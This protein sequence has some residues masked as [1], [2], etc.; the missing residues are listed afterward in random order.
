MRRPLVGA[1]TTLL[2]GGAA[3]TGIGAAPA[4][5]ASQTADAPRASAPQAG[6]AV[7][8]EA[9]VKAKPKAVDFAG[10]VAL[11]NCSGS[12]IRL[13]NSADND[14][15]LVLTNG[16]CLETGMPG[17]GDVI[18][19]QASSRTFSLLNSTA[20]KAGTLRASKVAYATMTDTDVTLYQLTTTYAQIKKSYGINALNLS[21][22]H[23]ATGTPIKVV[24]GYWKRI[25]SCNVDG[26][27]H[28]LRE[29]DWTW[30]DSLRYTPSCNT[31]GGTS[32]S[33][34]IDVNTGKVIAVNNTGNENGE[35]CTENNPCEVDENGN[36]TVRRGINYAEQTYGITKCVTAGNRID[37]SLPGCALPKP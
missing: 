37:L 2:L 27:V 8:A 9:A 4:A 3:A 33:P 15:A 16:H 21:A 13:P 25:Y 23:P 20:G 32:G 29:G 7:Q 12:L 18:V 26:F 31:I 6:V 11:S 10:T 1:L 22:D 5:A 30:K 24:S 14:P 17:A 34:V 36:V 19:D 35:R 28:E